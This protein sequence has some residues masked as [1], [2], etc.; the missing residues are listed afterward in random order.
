MFKRPCPACGAN[1]AWTGPRIA[2]ESIW[3]AKQSC[4][5]CGVRLRLSRNVPAAICMLLFIV[6][7]FIGVFGDVR[8]HWG[9]RTAY[10][11]IGL[12]GLVYCYLSSKSRYE[13]DQGAS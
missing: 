7:M 5:K 10:V 3:K 2:H 6:G 13:L 4:P 12:W 8:E 1:L 11:L 9:S